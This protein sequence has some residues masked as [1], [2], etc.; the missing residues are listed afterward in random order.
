[1][2]AERNRETAGGYDT[3]PFSR[4]RRRQADGTRFGTVQG[5]IH[6]L[7][8]VDVTRAR[9]LIRDHKARTGEQWS[10][11]AFAIACLGRAVGE[12][13]RV[14]GYRDW[15]NRLVVFHDVDV[16][17][18]VEGEAE[19]GEKVVLAFFVRAANSKSF[20]Q[21]HDEIRTFQ[22]PG[23][24]RERLKFMRLFA[25]LPGFMRRLFY[26]AIQRSPHLRKN[27]FCTVSM[28][29]VG[30][31]GRPAPGAV[32]GWGVPISHHTLAITLGGI[33]PRQV[34]VDG[35]PEDREF[36]CVTISVDHAMVDGAPAARFAARFKELME[37]A[38]ELG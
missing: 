10:F 30:M 31:F 9:Q 19:D 27:G 4:M 22:Q 29:S 8:E 3:Y 15:R 21:I 18:M 26:A 23:Q 2:K 36:L 28:S 14:H 20:R 32:G 7:I 13:P 35:R 16:N 34:L 6:G 12:N 17:T 37:S 25:M 33:A 11:T 1:M 24:A 5:A 38:E